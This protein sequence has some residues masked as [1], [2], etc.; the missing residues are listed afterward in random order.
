ML[1]FNVAWLSRRTFIGVMLGA[2]QSMTPRLRPVWN[3]DSNTAR[4]PP[5]MWLHVPVPDGSQRGSVVDLS[6]WTLFA[7][8]GSVLVVQ[9][10]IA[11]HVAE[12]MALNGGT[13]KWALRQVD[14]TTVVIKEVGADCK[15]LVSL[16][17]GLAEG[18][19][20][21]ERNVHERRGGLQWKYI[22]AAEGG[23]L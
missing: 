20:M 17:D 6:A 7:P 15:T 22:V 13:R 12:H 21:C 8:P 14:E 18:Q 5:P 10:G 19:D 16:V 23:V 3:H 11:R 9:G 4:L 2:I 1:L